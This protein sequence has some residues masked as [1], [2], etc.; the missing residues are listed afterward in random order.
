[1][2]RVDVRALHKAMKLLRE[3]AQRRDQLDAKLA[4]GEPWSEVAQFAAYCC[5]TEKLRLLP[6]QEPPMHADLDGAVDDFPSAGRVAASQL[7]RRLLDAGL[8][9]FEPDPINA[10]AAAADAAAQA[11]GQQPPAT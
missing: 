9:R 8:S 4:W 5:Q 7:L 1:M 11:A 10:L 6:W 3:D 2:K